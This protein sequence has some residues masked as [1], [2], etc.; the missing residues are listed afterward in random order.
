MTPATTPNATTE[1]ASD[2]P[3]SRPQRPQ[4]IAELG[5][6]AVDRLAFPFAWIL[7]SAYLLNFVGRR[8]ISHDEGAIAHPAERVLLG[9]LPHRDFMDPYTG[10]LSYLHALAFE[11]LG[12]NLLSPRIVVLILAVIWIPVVYWIARR[13]VRPTAA[14]WIVLIAVA[15]SLPNYFAALP[16]WYNLFLATFSAAA[17]LRYVDDRRSLWLVL[18]GLCGGLAILAKISGLFLV[19]AALVS[20]TYLESSE[21]ATERNQEPHGRAAAYRAFLTTCLIV[22]VGLLLGM[23]WIQLEPATFLQFVLPVAALV[24]FVLW[25]EWRSPPHAGSAVRFRRL[26]AMVT[27]FGIGVLLP[28]SIFL[29]PFILAGAV[30]ELLVGVFVLPAQRF[31]FASRPPAPLAV[32]LPALLFLLVL[33]A[34]PSIRNARW[35]IGL[36]CVLLGLLLTADPLIGVRSS[37]PLITVAGVWVL[38]TKPTTRAADPYQRQ[39]LTLLLCSAAFGG[40]VQYPFAAPIYFCYFAPLALLALTGILQMRSALLGRGPAAMRVLSFALL[41]SGLA[42]NQRFIAGPMPVE[43]EQFFFFRQQTER[44]D[45]QRG[46]VKVTAEDKRSYERLA[47]LIQTHSRGPYI[48]AG[49]DA[50]QVYFLTDRRNPTPYLYAFFAAPGRYEEDVLAGI[51]AHEIDIVAINLRPWFSPTHSDRLTTALRLRFPSSERVG[52]FE[53]RWRE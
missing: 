39:A 23:V 48:Y 35:M 12:T 37:L 16:S 51:D 41:L 13:F 29:I 22:L 34:L 53:V 10:G 42:L 26:L 20:L 50:S 14:A 32:A 52:Y 9:E 11:V 36:T 38:L 46:Q 45:L 8:W 47:H 15:W 27:P 30:S 28:I 31:Y 17:L 7:S 2:V 40:L 44:L 3:G 49:P 5:T 43:S 21:P 6:T 18:A 24:A 33:V 1:S 4:S 25:E 19:A